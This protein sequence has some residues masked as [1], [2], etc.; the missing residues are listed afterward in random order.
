[1]LTENIRILRKNKG[2]T[3]EELAVR[4]NVVRQ[5][6]SKWEKGLSVPDAVLLEKLAEILE[7]DV[8]TLLGETVEPK[9][10]SGEIAEQLSRISEQIAVR[11]R[12]SRKIWRIV[13]IILLSVILSVS[14]II[15][16]LFTY[17]IGR[18]EEQTVQDD[19]G[20][21]TLITDFDSES[22]YLHYRDLLLSDKQTFYEIYT[23]EAD[24]FRFRFAESKYDTADEATFYPKYICYIKY[25]DSFPE[26]TD[27]TVKYV[28]GKNNALESTGEAN[29]EIM[30]LSSDL[31]KLPREI[32]ITVRKRGEKTEEG[33][34]IASASFKVYSVD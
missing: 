11:N 32:I 6:V 25:D 2:M 10:D 22:P 23:D 5:T 3:Q 8:S 15:I 31:A 29:N 26:D 30:I 9:T 16:F 27:M 21:I 24:G 7:T 4:L 13:W 20:E 14:L 28:Y 34:V 18:V 17:R 1:M 19:C 12:R 33:A